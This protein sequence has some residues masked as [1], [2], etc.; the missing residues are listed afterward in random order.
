MPAKIVNNGQNA[1]KKCRNIFYVRYFDFAAWFAES[2]MQ[3]RNEAE[4]WFD[5]E[6]DR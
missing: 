5:E 6:I 1:K 2:F 4:L 3:P